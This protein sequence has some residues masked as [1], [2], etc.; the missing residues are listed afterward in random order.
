MSKIP[1]TILPVSDIQ[2]HTLGREKGSISKAVERINY[3]QI[4]SKKGPTQAPRGDNQIEC[5]KV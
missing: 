4:K 2:S 5:Y 3:T 1:L